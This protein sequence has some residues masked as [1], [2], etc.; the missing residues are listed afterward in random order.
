MTIARR[1]IAARNA[2]RDQRAAVAS[3]A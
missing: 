2:A 1:E 3:S